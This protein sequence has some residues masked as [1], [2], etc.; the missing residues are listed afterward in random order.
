MRQ[1]LG[2]AVFAGMLGVTMFGVFLTP[3]F[4]FTIDWLSETRV[5]RS[6]AA[7]IGGRFTLELL[8]FGILRLIVIASRRSPEPALVKPSV[9]GQN[10]TREP[11]TAV[12][13]DPIR[14]R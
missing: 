8:T 13:A 4:Y 6:R 5:L 9:N 7:A 14:K 1:T 11:S 3:V 2:T 10:A 12:T